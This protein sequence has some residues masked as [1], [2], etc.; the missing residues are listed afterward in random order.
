[1][2]YFDATTIGDVGLLENKGQSTNV[3]YFFKNKMEKS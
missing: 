1:M 2:D 3:D